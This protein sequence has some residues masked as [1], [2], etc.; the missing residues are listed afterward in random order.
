MKL[1]V[2]LDTRQIISTPRSRVPLKE[3][4]ARRGETIT[5]DVAFVTHGKQ[6]SVA[7]NNVKLAAYKGLA[8]RTALVSAISPIVVG[9]GSQAVYRFNQVYFG[10][11]SLLALLGN[12]QDTTLIFEVRAQVAYEDIVTEPLK[13]VITQSTNTAT[14]I[15]PTD[16]GVSTVRWYSQIDSLLDG[17]VG[18]YPLSGIVTVPLPVRSVVQ[19]CINNEIQDWLLKAGTDAPIAMG[20][21]HPNDYNSS[22][23]AKVWIRLR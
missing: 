17:D 5:V 8:E 23:N 11:D 1:F 7:A 3:I 9:R 6:V 19:I 21:V 4:R 13:M 12:Q 16:T 18:D 2:N 20:I 10:G 22:T 14:S 15:L